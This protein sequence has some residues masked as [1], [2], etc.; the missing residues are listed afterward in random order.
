MKIKDFLV[1]MVGSLILGILV[2]WLINYYVGEIKNYRTIKYQNREETK[3]QI[4]FLRDSFEM[5]YY[6]KQLDSTYNFNHSK[7]K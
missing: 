5:E 6:K 4:R 7:I 1:G 3:E 2:I